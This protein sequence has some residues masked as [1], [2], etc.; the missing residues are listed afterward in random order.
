[1]P[2]NN[3]TFWLVFKRKSESLERHIPFDFEQEA[4]QFIWDYQQDQDWEY[5]E[6]YCDDE[7]IARSK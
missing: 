6:L 1:M 3:Y 5:Y 7:L 4:E 2:G